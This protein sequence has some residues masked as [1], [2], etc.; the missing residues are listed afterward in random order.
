[1]PT[2]AVVATGMFLSGS[3]RQT[4][5][6]PGSATHTAP[7]ATA[8]P[9]ERNFETAILAST[10]F[11]LGSI[12]VRGE[13]C[14]GPATHTDPAPVVI[15]PSD[16][17]VETGRI[18]AV[19]RPVRGS[20]RV[21]VRSPEAYHRDP[22]P[23]VIGP[24]SEYGPV[25]ARSRVLMDFATVSRSGSISVTRP[26]RASETHTPRSSAAMPLGVLPTP[27]VPSSVRSARPK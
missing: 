19:T 5:S 26:L 3:T 9:P 2:C 1:M 14:D 23:V 21:I 16:S 11:V 27:T 18:R 10:L 22:N 6:P 25:S 7:P 13:P 24:A 12:R 15:A 20:I 17:P 8:T 4:W